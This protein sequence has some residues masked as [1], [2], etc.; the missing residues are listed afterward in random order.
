MKKRKYHYLFFLFSMFVL[1]NNTNAQ[2]NTSIKNTQLFYFRHKVTELQLEG[3]DFFKPYLAYLNNEK[4]AIAPL[5]DTFI[6]TDFYFHIHKEMEAKSPY[7]GILDKRYLDSYLD[8]V[9]IRTR[10]PIIDNELNSNNSA[11]LGHNFQSALSYKTNL[12]HNSNDLELQFDIEC[13]EAVDEYNILV[14]WE[15]FGNNGEKLFS[16]KA[17]DLFS[18]DWFEIHYEPKIIY[19]ASRISQS[20]LIPEDLKEIVS[21]IK[22]HIINY[23]QRNLPIT[24][25]NV[26]LLQDGVYLVDRGDSTFDSEYDAFSTKW[27]FVKQQDTEYAKYLFHKRQPLLDAISD[28]KKSLINID[29]PETKILLTLPDINIDYYIEKNEIPTLLNLISYFINEIKIRYEKWKA[30]H[31]DASISLAGI[32]FLDEELDGKKAEKFKPVLDFINKEL[33]L[34]NWNLYGSPYLYFKD[35]CMVQ[36]T[37]SQ[38]VYPYF[39]TL[40][41]QP[42]AFYNHSVRGNVDRD[43]LRIGA[44]LANKLGLDFNIES[45]LLNPGETYGRINDYFSYGEK[46][47]YINSSKLYYDNEG[48]HYLNSVSPE[49]GQRVDYDNLFAFIEQSR[50]GTL[51]N[52]KFEMVD[53]DQFDGFYGWDGKYGVSKNIFPDMEERKNKIILPARST[54]SSEFIV[55]TNQKE[56]ELNLRYKGMES[57]SSQPKFD[58]KLLF[59]KG[60]GDQ[61]MVT[62]SIV[63]GKNPYKIKFPPHALGLIF[64]IL[65]KEDRNI[66]FENI[67]LNR[68]D[69]LQLKM[70]VSENQPKFLKIESDIKY[71]NYSL[72]LGRFQYAETFQQITVESG[73]PYVLKLSYKE[74]L[75]IREKIIER[76]AFVGIQ[77]FNQ[78]GQ[79]IKKPL[80]EFEFDNDNE[81]SVFYIDA[82]TQD[83]SEETL[84]LNFSKEVKSVKIRLENN[85]YSNEILFD[86]IHF[87]Q[88]GNVEIR[89][90]E[91]LLSKNKWTDTTFPLYTSYGTPLFY[92]QL[93]DVSNISQLEF[94][95]LVR[96]TKSL[97]KKDNMLLIEF[98]DQEHNKIN[99]GNLV[100]KNK[101]Y[102]T[103][104]L[105][106]L[107]SWGCSNNNSAKWFHNQWSQ[108]KRIINVPNQ[109]FFMKISFYKINKSSEKLIMLNPF[110]QIV[111]SK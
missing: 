74:N 29:L 88:L 9:F 34:N 49:P 92:N 96:E 45:T 66:A 78:N 21:E 52:P 27:E 7:L 103:E 57:L 64:Q 8:D 65:N 26:I 17:T 33:E 54:I 84:E 31:E 89:N 46:Y 19:G 23:D 82:I 62:D 95:A 71:G 2:I 77:T 73:S 36:S 106:T 63:G 38:D 87:Q 40:W 109:A 81:M 110:L 25:D 44:N 90:S 93:I 3:K 99:S 100:E 41:Q 70:Y 14:G 4:E 51:I 39:T 102:E 53:N 20:I 48:A 6:L 101:F 72:Q 91:N 85:G 97:Y 50:Q 98:F 108:L 75:P 107:N 83:W 15:F 68:A 79:I 5:M 80:P 47:G 12:N 32:Y 10:V 60:N 69:S 35:K 16:E 61:I 55:A 11:Y 67:Y 58:I 37:F 105:F 22:I 24:I 111:R 30:N 1:V 28:A 104:F 76:K 43:L 59:F 86:N 18:K 13:K 42:N 94:S 56:I